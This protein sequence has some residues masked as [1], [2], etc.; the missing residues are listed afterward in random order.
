VPDLTDG[1]VEPLRSKVRQL[2]ALA[3]G[4]ITVTSGRRSYAEQAALRVKNGCPDVYRSP[5]STCRVPTAIPGTSRHEAGL[6]VDLGGDLA[7]AAK[8]APQVGLKAAVRGEPWHFEPVDAKASGGD[9]GPA[10]VGGRIVTGVAAVGT[11]G[12]GIVDGILRRLRDLTITAMIVSGAAALVVMG[13]YRTVTGRSLTRDAAKVGG[14]LGLAA[15]TGGTGTAVKAGAA[16]A[17]AT[18]APT[19]TPRSAR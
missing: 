4:A 3:G 7:L 6:A 15:T 13:G 11:G 18:K 17:A 14:E 10:T 12:D 5:S 9:A 19:A 1:L 16:K 8:L 2:L